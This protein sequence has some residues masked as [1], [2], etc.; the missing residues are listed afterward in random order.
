MPNNLKSWSLYRAN[1]P[2]RVPYILEIWDFLKRYF[3]RNCTE[4]K[5]EDVEWKKNKKKVTFYPSLLFAMLT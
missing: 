2:F 5:I 4:V 1:N 3:Q